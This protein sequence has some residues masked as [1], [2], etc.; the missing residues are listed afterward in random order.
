MDATSSSGYL[1]YGG[2]VV[3]CDGYVDYVVVRGEIAGGN[4]TVGFIKAPAGQEVPVISPGSGISDSVNMADD[5]TGYR[6]DN[7]TNVGGVV[8]NTFSAGDVIMFT[9]NT[10]TGLQDAIATAVLVFDWDNQL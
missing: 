6:F 4:T 8:T 5:D 10:T 3:P 1:E 2:Y 7:F 9:L